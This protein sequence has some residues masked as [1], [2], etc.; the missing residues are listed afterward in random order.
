MQAAITSL[1][2]HKMLPLAQLMADASG[3]IIRRYF[4]S[5]VVVDSKAD[6]SPV[7]RADR[8]AETAMRALIEAQFPAHGIVGEEHG[9]QRSDA[10]YQWVLDPIDGTRGFIAG[11]PLFTTL[12]ALLYRGE[13]VLGIINQ[14][15]LNERWVGISGQESTLNFKNVAVR[16]CRALGSAVLATTSVDYFTPE[17]AQKFSG[18]RKQCANTALGGDAYAYAMLASGHL[19]IV[20]D[21]GMKPYDFCALKP[22]VEG[23]GGVIT[24]WKGK[25]LTLS[26]DGSVLAAATQELHAAALALLK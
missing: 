25:P 24:D 19:D 8:E 7:T 21:A 23:A 17:Q 13:P 18:L 5:G 1:P 11:Y 22:V 14:P 26:S 15:I 2:I 10:E 20:V 12:I 9:N 3:E 6:A 16:D 4:R